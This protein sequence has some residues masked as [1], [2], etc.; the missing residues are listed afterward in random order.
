[1]SPLGQGVTW[2]ENVGSL[3][4]LHRGLAKLLSSSWTCGP[5]LNLFWASVSISAKS[6]HVFPECLYKAVTGL[7]DSGLNGIPAGVALSCVC[8]EGAG[9][10][11]LRPVPPPDHLTRLLC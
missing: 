6:R 1:M 10:A 2:G 4:L 5:Q 11:V 8:L 7:A 9:L 3:R